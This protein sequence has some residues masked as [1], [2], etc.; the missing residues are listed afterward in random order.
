MNLLI[1]VVQRA[2]RERGV[3]S[4]WSWGINDLC[5]LVSAFLCMACYLIGPGLGGNR[6]MAMLWWSTWRWVLPHWVE[7][8]CLFGPERRQTCGG[9]QYCV[10][11]S[12]WGCQQHLWPC[13]G[14]SSWLSAWPRACP[15]GTA[16][17]GLCIHFFE[18][19]FCE[20]HKINT[21]KTLRTI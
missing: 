11:M 1:L 17:V 16:C 5:C 2:Y 15:L 20:D 13:W 18:D 3:L 10:H 4:L 19:T 14:I 9:C 8:L 21:Y 12:A 7:P 6:G